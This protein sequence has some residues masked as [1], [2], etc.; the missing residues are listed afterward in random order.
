MAPHRGHWLP[1]LLVFLGTCVLPGICK[2]VS[3]Q[4]LLNNTVVLPCHRALAPGESLG[5]FRV[6]WQMGDIV[7]HALME[8]HH[9]EKYQ[10]QSYL[11]RTWVD[12]SNL[13][14]S[15]SGVQVSDEGSYSCH[16]QKRDGN[17]RAFESINADYSV[18]LSVAA[19]YSQPV[20]SQDVAPDNTCCVNLTCR[21]QDGYPLASVVWYNLTGEQ[22]IPGAQDTPIPL[23]D[24]VSHLYSVISPLVVEASSCLVVVCSVQSP[25][26][27]AVNS[28]HFTYDG[29]KPVPEPQKNKTAAIV[30]GT[31][32]VI[33]VLVVSFLVVKYRALCCREDN[34]VL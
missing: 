9:E 6:Y 2:V 13:S 16:I 31:F 11:N 25:H 17:G 30:L 20:I 23:Q 4:A 10:N 8:G 1:H 5:D 21:S 22:V 33:I 27:P 18:L 34:A 32:V 12:H 3:I 26:F 24:P 15:L 28:S 14:L 29:C 7:V 19:A